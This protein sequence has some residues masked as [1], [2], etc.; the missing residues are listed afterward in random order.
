MTTRSSALL[1]R[2]LPFA[3]ASRSSTTFPQAFHQCQSQYTTTTTTTEAVAETTDDDKKKGKWF[4]LPP[5]VSTVDGAAL[6]KEL[7]G[8]RSER[9]GDATTGGAATT[10]TALKWVLRCCPQLP[11]SLVQKLFRLRQV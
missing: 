4:T 1:R 5:F 3:A 7:S 11:R 6:G 9:K 10:T 2:S 8:R